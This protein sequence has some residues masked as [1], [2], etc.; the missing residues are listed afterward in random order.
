[1]RR[2]RERD[3]WIAISQVET[4]KWRGK[5]NRCATTRQAGRV[6]EIRKDEEGK[7]PGE[8]KE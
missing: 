5:H 2:K 8:S 3:G 1:M 6:R 4:F 7:Q